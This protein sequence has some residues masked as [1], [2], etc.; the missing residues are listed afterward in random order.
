MSTRRKLFA[1]VVLAF[2]SLWL[3]GFSD[4]LFL[5]L[6]FVSLALGLWAARDISRTMSP[7][8]KSLLL[9][10]GAWQFACLGCLFVY[11]HTVAPVVVRLYEESYGD[12]QADYGRFERT[13]V[14][15]S[16]LT[17]TAPATLV[18]LL[19]YR[20]ISGYRKALWRTL[21]TLVLWE[22]AVVSV[23]IWSYETSFAYNVIHEWDWAIF[24]APYNLYGLRNFMVH[25]LIA[26]LICTTPVCALALWLYGAGPAVAESSRRNGG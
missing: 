8:G 11:S 10:I 24:G 9:A 3:G 5:S 20:A 21:A 6:A 26:W 17:I 18:T 1:S 23:L 25:R 12:I 14:Y 15:I 19:L 22:L 7:R 2:L 16:R 4:S 13:A